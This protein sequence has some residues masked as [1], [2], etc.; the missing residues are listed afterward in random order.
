MAQAPPEILVPR[1]GDTGVLWTILVSGLL[2]GAVIVLVLF[3][4]PRFFGV[5]KPLVSY[6]VDLV[7]TKE[8]GGTNLVPGSGRGATQ[9]SGAGEP[10]KIKS[11]PAIEPKPAKPPAEIAVPKREKP[12]EKARPESKPAAV[13]PPPELKKAEP[14]PPAKPKPAEI[15]KPKAKEPAAPAQPKPAAKVVKAP[16]PPQPKPVPAKKVPAV[17]P[18]AQQA[19]S[20]P[21]RPQPAQP[22]VA[23]PQVAKQEAAKPGPAKPQVAKPE[24]KQANA[25]VAPSSVPEKESDDAE[26]RDRAILAAVQ[27]RAEHV[28]GDSGRGGSSGASEGGPI[29]I[30]PG[31]GTGGKVVSLKYLLY[32]NDMI[33]RIKENWVWAGAGGSLEAVVRFDIR[34][35][36]QVA[37]VRLVRSSG[38]PSYDASVERAVL[39]VKT[40]GPPPEE[41]ANGVELTFRPDDLRS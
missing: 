25:A 37:G 18:K 35:D 30:G 24:P 38:D 23:K 9:R 31:E 2:H 11:A 19:K 20:E 21:P 16:D 40:L 17:A 12:A 29:S 39:A 36:G 8:V 6:T 4:P 13:A 10:A 27:R 15:V 5:S 7:S 14:V 32:Y 3:A 22:Q 1:S 33:T 28:K 41:F 34:P 26:K